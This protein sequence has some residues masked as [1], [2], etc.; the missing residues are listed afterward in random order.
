MSTEKLHSFGNSDQTIL[1]GGWDV[2]SQDSL[3]TRYILANGEHFFRFAYNRQ[4]RSGMDI[5]AVY[6]KEPGSL[7]KASVKLVF[8]FP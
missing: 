4:V 6:D 3:A 2:T 7:A 5:F 8:S 1:S